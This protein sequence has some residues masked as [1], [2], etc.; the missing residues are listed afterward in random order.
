MGCVL[1]FLPQWK[2]KSFG[3]WGLNEKIVV[4]KARKTSPL[5][6]V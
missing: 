2:S 1:G 6:W 4:T 3:N 5:A